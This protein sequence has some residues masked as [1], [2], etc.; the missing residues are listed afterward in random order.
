MILYSKPQN[1]TDIPSTSK[2]LHF[3]FMLH[4]LYNYTCVG[5]CV[6]DF[7]VC[8]MDFDSHDSGAISL[9]FE[10]LPSIIFLGLIS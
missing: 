9:K 5:T 8:C 4:L 10:F 3:A 2:L 6:M 1:S 7:M